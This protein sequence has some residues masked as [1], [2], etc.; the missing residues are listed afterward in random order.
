MV[1]TG[2]GGGQRSKPLPSSTWLFLGGVG[3]LSVRA[4][5][6]LLK[7]LDGALTHHGLSAKLPVVDDFD[8]DRRAVQSFLG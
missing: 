3:L 1:E 7:G 8:D 4:A 6:E 5:V 2:K